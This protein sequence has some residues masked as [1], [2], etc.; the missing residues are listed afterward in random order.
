M[1]PHAS[2]LVWPQEGNGRAV[3]IQRNAIHNVLHRCSLSASQ[4]CSHLCMSQTNRGMRHAPGCKTD[5]DDTDSIQAR[6]HVH[7][8]TQF[9]PMD[10]WTREQTVV[11][12]SLKWSTENRSYTRYLAL[13]RTRDINTFI[14]AQH[15]LGGHSTSGLTIL[16]PLIRSSL[17]VRGARAAGSTQSYRCTQSCWQFAAVTRAA[18]SQE[19][20]KWT[21]SVGINGSLC[22]HFSF[23]MTSLPSCLRLWCFFY[24]DHDGGGEVMWLGRHPAMPRPA[25]SSSWSHTCTYIHT[26]ILLPWVLPSP[27]PRV[28][29]FLNGLEVGAHGADCKSHWMWFLILGFINKIYFHDSLQYLKNL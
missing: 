12:L 25:L 8:H 10:V 2:D 23:K 18:K 16:Q 1:F 26:Y 5:A 20:S 29:L 19:Y 7:T 21:F 6:M 13:A 4:W 27:P 22:K 17:S 28:L 9:K 3:W 14:Y 11:V 15:T 24:S